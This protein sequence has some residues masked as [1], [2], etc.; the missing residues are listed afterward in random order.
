[1]KKLLAMSVLFGIGAVSL[2]FADSKADASRPPGVEATS[3]VPLAKDAGFVVMKPARVPPPGSAYPVLSGYFMAF[4]D[5]KWVRL[6][7]ESEERFQ[8]AS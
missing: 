7:P 6:E 8:H 2:G 4:H 1:M 5:G 3:W